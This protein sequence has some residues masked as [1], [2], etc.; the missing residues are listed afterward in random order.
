LV[1]R[2]GAELCHRRGQ[3]QPSGPRAEEEVVGDVVER[4]ARG[5]GE[6]DLQLE[7]REPLEPIGVGSWRDASGRD[8]L[9]ARASSPGLGAELAEGLEGTREAIAGL[10]A[11]C[12]FT[13]D[14]IDAVAGGV[15]PDQGMGSDEIDAVR[16]RSRSWIIRYIDNEMV[17]LRGLN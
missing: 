9:V 6:R 12:D 11:R 17:F 5:R 3:Q 15:L 13:V 10:A 2:L 14:E 4:R 1:R 8:D 7:P 16:G